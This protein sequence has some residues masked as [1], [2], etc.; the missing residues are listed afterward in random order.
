M[1]HSLKSS[2]SHGVTKTH[3]PENTNPTSSRKSL[4]SSSTIVMT[5]N[6][7]T[8]EP[9]Y[10]VLDRAGA[11]RAAAPRRACVRDGHKVPIRKC[12]TE[13]KTRNKKVANKPTVRLVNP[14]KSTQSG[15]TSNISATSEKKRARPVRTQSSVARDGSR[16][17]RTQSSVARDG[18]R[19]IRSS[20]RRRK[21]RHNY[22][23]VTE[24]GPVKRWVFYRIY[25]NVTLCKVL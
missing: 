3:D 14:T 21:R 17:I 4:K 1:R 24:K 12:Q 18:S 16:P 11:A 2:A 22:Q 13:T 19:P 5:N 20:S 23:N 15:S 10:N 6:R 9:Y 25:R 8:N 7:S